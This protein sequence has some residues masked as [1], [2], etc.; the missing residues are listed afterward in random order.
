MHECVVADA[1]IRFNE[2]KSFVGSPECDATKKSVVAH[3]L[4]LLDHCRGRH[5][6]H[7]NGVARGVAGALDYDAVNMRSTRLGNRC[8]DVA[9]QVVKAIIRRCV[10]LLPE[11]AHLVV[12]LS[13]VVSVR[14]MLRSIQSALG[15]AIVVT[16]RRRPRSIHV[17]RPFPKRSDEPCISAL[18][19]RNCLIACVTIA[20]R[21][22][23]PTATL[24]GCSTN[25]A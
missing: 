13:L 9:A 25:C 10:G 20:R 8:A 6:A 17:W 24:A 1:V 22:I 23:A 16:S 7:C 11:N 14:R 2:S 5:A 12:T 3:F 4:T 19:A 15:R 21:L 18:R